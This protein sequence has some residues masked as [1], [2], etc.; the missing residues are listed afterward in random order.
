[1]FKISDLKPTDEIL[2]FDKEHSEKRPTLYQVR[3]F[4]NEYKERP[5]DFGK[6]YNAWKKVP[7]LDKEDIKSKLSDYFAD[8]VIESEYFY[9]GDDFTTDDLWENRKLLMITRILE[10]MLGD[11]GYFLVP[12]RFEVDYSELVP[13]KPEPQPDPV[14]SRKEILEEKKEKCF[15]IL[16]AELHSMEEVLQRPF[17]VGD[18]GLAKSHVEQAAYDLGEVVFELA[19]LEKEENQCGTT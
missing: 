11:S 6:A 10:C 16:I 13:V 19:K 9:G 18:P 8:R 4:I 17:L 14:P 5:E 2:V 15:R 12:G 7:D 1:M 3:D